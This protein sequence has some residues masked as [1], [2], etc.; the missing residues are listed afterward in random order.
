MDNSKAVAIS[1][2]ILKSRWYLLK[3]MSSLLK[4]G[5]NETTNKI[6]AHILDYLIYQ[7]VNNIYRSYFVNNY[8]S[9]GILSKQKNK[10][11]RFILRP[12]ISVIL[13]TYNTR[14]SHL[15]E[16]IKSVSDQTYDNWELCITD[17]AS[18]DPKVRDTILDYSKMDKR[19]KYSFRKQN[20]HISRASNDS[21]KLATGKYI[22][23]LDHD[24][25]LWPNALYEVVK[26]INKKP[27][28][29][30]LYSD[31]DKLNEAGKHISPFFKPDWS[32][33]YIRSINY[34][35]H[36]TV[37]KKT[38][39]DKAGG[40][41][42]GY[43][44]AQDWDLFLRVINILEKDKNIHILNPKNPIQHIPR[45]LYSWRQSSSSTASSKSVDTVKKYAFDNQ[46]KVLEDDLKRTGYKGEV[47]RTK[48][49]GLWRTKYNLLGK[50]LVSI[51]IPTKDQYLYL[52]KSVGSIIEKTTYDNYQII[53][54]DTGSK[55]DKVFEYYESLK[56]LTKKVS[57]LNWK[58]KF[59]YSA[60]CNFGVKKCKG[61]YVVLLNNDTEV[62]MP[63]WIESMLEYAQ[64][65]ETGAVGCK[66]LYPNNTIQHAGVVLGMINDDNILPTPGHIFKND[67]DGIQ[68]S[69]YQMIHSI[70]NYSAL[71]AACIMVKKNKYQEI[72]GLDEKLKIAFNDVDFCLKLLKQGYNNV[73]TPYSMIYH[74]ES[75]SV[76]KIYSKSRNIGLYKR[77]QNK[78]YNRWKFLS[79]QDPFF[80]LPDEIKNLMNV[81]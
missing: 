3:V 73:Y 81:L 58:G 59:N 20:G 71:T 72:G 75:I 17:D 46:K 35:T 79:D 32:P 47:I 2:L 49:L 14:I 8:P 36:F 77:E 21:L 5:G 61:S 69:Y 1:D 40:F 41:R 7:K 51:I 53:I 76:G 23:L 74:H 45:I 31:E 44:G 70:R 39:V 18:T 34:I 33:N 80:R 12:L 6:S 13:P 25:F 66:L 54:V 15:K 60:V 55:D 29:M 65:P 63:D 10:S 68:S 27:H 11:D 37:I 26:H 16:C 50:P 28:S 9:P 48:Y 52:T 22:A 19:I 62:I 4:N 64:L 30:F 78:F 42:S 24:D 43:E 38:L 56:K 57:V 67:T